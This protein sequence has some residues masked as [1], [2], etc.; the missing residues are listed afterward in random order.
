LFM[1]GGIIPSKGESTIIEVEN[2]NV[3][4]LRKGSISEEMIEELN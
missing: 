1:D 2:N 4:I 3:K